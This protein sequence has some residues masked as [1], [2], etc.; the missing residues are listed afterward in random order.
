MIAATAAALRADGIANTEVRVGDAEHLELADASFAAVLCS[1][2]VFFFPD[3]LAAL[4][5]CRRVL[6]PGGRLAASTFLC[7]RGG[8]VWAEEVARE[9]GQDPQ[10]LR[11]P[12]R[13]AD[14]LRSALGQAGFE[15]IRSV[16]RQACFVFADSDAYVAWVWSHAGRRVIEGLDPAGL[17]RY[18]ELATERLTAHAVDGGFELIQN[19]QLTL[20]RRP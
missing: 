8:Y 4:A 15:E 2:G 16:E 14:G 19:V 1:F 13:T 18:R 10:P 9:M 3:P 6:R 5:E 11:S 7:G 17:Q 20:A 12:V